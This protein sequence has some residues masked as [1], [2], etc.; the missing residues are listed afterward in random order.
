MIN[1]FLLNLYKTFIFSCDEF[2]GKITFK[3]SRK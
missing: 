2:D 3:L 1:N